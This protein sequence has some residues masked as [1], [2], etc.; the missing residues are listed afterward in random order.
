MCPIE[1]YCGLSS[2][3][4]R[5]FNHIGPR[6][7]FHM[8]SHLGYPKQLLNAWGKFLA[9]FER[10]FDIRGCIGDSVLSDS[11]FPEGDPLSIVAMLLVNWG[12]HVYMKIFAPKV[13][14]FSFV[15]NLT[16]A[17]QQST[18][19]IQGYFAMLTYSA[20]LGL[21]LDDENLCLG[22]DHFTA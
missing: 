17:A 3:V 13:Q 19:V 2:D 5:A 21:S 6:Q 22:I 9:T 18:H 11:G 14:A 7:G 12:Y 4:R 15:D 16:L 1:P 20:L 10:R 8:G